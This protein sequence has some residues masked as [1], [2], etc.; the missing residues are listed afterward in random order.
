MLTTPPSAPQRRTI[1]AAE[2]VV[3]C[4]DAWRSLR[5]ADP[6]RWAAHDEPPPE[7]L[8]LIASRFVRFGAEVSVAKGGWRILSLGEQRVAVPTAILKAAK[9]SLRNTAPAAR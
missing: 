7:A 5:R 9:A 3:L 2:A 4:L 8:E 1:S 6:D